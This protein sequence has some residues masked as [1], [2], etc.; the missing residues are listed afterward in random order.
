[1]LLRPRWRSCAS[2]IWVE[3][4][5]QMNLQDAVVVITGSTRGFGN[6]VARAL[7]ARGARVVISGR[8]K[9]TVDAVVSQLAELGIVS[10]LA[11]DV[12]QAEQVYALARHALEVSG[13]IDV[14]IN[15]AGMTPP[16]GGVLDFEPEAAVQAFRVNCMGTLHGTQTA[17][18]VMKEQGHGTIV[19]LY[20]RG[21]FLRPASPSGFYG[22]TKAWITSFSRTMAAEYK[23]LPIRIIGFSPGMMTTDMLV[24]QEIVGSTI[25]DRM[26]SFPMA[27]KALSQPPEVPAAELVRLLQRNEKPFVEYR[28]MRGMRLGR[29]LLRLAWMGMN[30]RAR[31]PEQEFVVRPAFKPPVGRGV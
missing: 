8:K 23:D 19:N 20:G 26:R 25:A 15:N 14:W 1:M 10:G 16:P 22:A 18:A 11:C 21:S 4:S 9:E 17:F 5:S 28:F 13:R 29:M 3:A 31:P 6:A 24:Q 7:L 2:S 12:R 30:R 27:L